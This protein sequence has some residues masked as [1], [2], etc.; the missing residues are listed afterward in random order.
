[1]KRYI[2]SMALAAAVLSS[3]T[4]DEVITASN[5]EIR[6]TTTVETTSRAVTSYCANNLPAE[7]T[8][9]SANKDLNGQLVTDRYIP[10]VSVSGNGSTYNFTD[11]NVRYWPEGTLDFLAY[12]NDEGTFDESTITSGATFRDFHVNPNV[13]NQVDFIYAT[14]RN[15]ARGNGAVALNF[16]HA[17]SQVVFRGMIATDNI[18]VEINSVTIGHLS[19]TGTFALAPTA[20]TA[21]NVNDSYHSDAPNSKTLSAGL[22]TWSQLDTPNNEYTITLDQPVTIDQINV[23]ETLSR[24][25]AGHSKEGWENVMCLI[26]QN[27][28]KWT[29]NSDLAAADGAYIGFGCKVWNVAQLNGETTKYQAFDG[30]FYMPLEIAWKQGFRYV[31]TIR[32]GEGDSPAIT[33]DGNPT[34]IKV[35]FTMSIEDFNEAQELQVSEIKRTVNYHLSDTETT[36][37]EVA[38]TTGSQW[39]FPTLETIPSKYLTTGKALAGWTLTKDSGNVDYKAGE[40]VYADMETESIDLYPVILN[41]K[42]VTYRPAQSCGKKN[43]EVK[44]FYS[45]G[46]SA[47][48]DEFPTFEEIQAMPDCDWVLP[49]GKTFI[50]WGEGPSDTT[51]LATPYITSRNPSLYPLFQ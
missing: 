14:K 17:L 21:T 44:Y 10:G 28:Q 23:A 1:M 40:I 12:A 16:R 49:E 29:G 42:T 2:F 37:T 6:F 33:A 43:F 27:Q 38:A 34:M 30:T 3:C 7:F 39:Y 46:T 50:G 48:I 35:G 31:Y 51:P 20:N 41:Y 19:G 13:A 8:V 26:P 45:T 4:Q 5:D 15:V 47:Q 9:W 18:I 11:G 32:F 22:G 24:T 25:P 36:V